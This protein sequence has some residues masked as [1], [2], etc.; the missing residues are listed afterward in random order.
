[1]GRSLTLTGICVECSVEIFLRVWSLHVDIQG[2]R[3]GM[4]DDIQ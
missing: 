1:M 3:I 2:H 4:G